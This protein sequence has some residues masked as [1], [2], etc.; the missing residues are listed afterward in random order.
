MVTDAE[1]VIAPALSVATA[2]STWLPTAKLAAIEYGALLSPPREVEPSKNCT[3][4]TEPSASLAL[5]W[6]VRFAGAI[7]LALFGGLV[8]ETE[9][10]W[11]APP[12]TVIL[13]VM[14][15]WGRQ[16]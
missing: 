13:P 12:L 7:K 14:K 5:A 9:G 4:V 16:K 6:M 10:G 1:V 11:F 15:V 8:I 3:W 2:V